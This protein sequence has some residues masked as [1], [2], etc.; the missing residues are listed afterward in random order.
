MKVVVTGGSGQLG[1]LVLERLVTD[2]TIKKIVAL[3][4]QP[5]IVPSTRIDWRIADMRDP[6]LERHLEGA[7]VLLHLA[8]IV[9]QRASVDTMR[10]TN[11][12]GSRRLFEAALQHGVRRIVYVSSVAAYGLGKDLPP[13]IVESTPRRRSATPTYAGN[14]YDVEE[15]LDIFEAQNPGTAVVRLR[16]G[17]MLGRRMTEVGSALLRRSVLP[18]F[19]SGRGPIVWD[20]DVADAVVR[21]LRDDAR[22]A[23]N[24][25]ADGPISFDDLSRLAHFTPLRVPKLAVS[26]AA[27]ASSALGRFLGDRRVDAGWLEAAE[28]DMHVSAEK[29]RVELGWKP[30]YPTSSD[31]A[32]AFGKEARR[33]TDRRVAWFFSMVRVLARR[34]ADGAELPDGGRLKLALHVDVAGPNGGDY[35][36]VIDDGEVTVRTGIPRPPDS[37]VSIRV[38]TLLEL[39]A[40]KGDVATAILVGKLRVRGEPLGRIVMSGI[41]D[42][43]RR[44][45]EAEGVQGK[46]ARGLSRWFDEGAHE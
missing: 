10:D 41:I 46:V 9:T 26:A 2:R 20:E 24:L 39:L 30:R 31:V 17:V 1:T 38:E 28:V 35:T 11:V 8:F 40:G 6:G 34:A 5:P 13:R 36:V 14:K 19:G 43:F 18:V 37:T 15:Y 32:I 12:E 7:E 45:A 27:R 42:A 25:V 33:T 44:A 29:A 16:P 22:G 23:F 4:L 3:D 21:S